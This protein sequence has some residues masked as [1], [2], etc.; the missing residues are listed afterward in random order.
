MITVLTLIICLLLVI[1][2]FLQVRCQVYKYKTEE[3]KQSLESKSRAVNH[4]QTVIKQM[5]NT[6]ANNVEQINNLTN[7]IKFKRNDN[8]N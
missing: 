7:K 8:N 3:L 4:L 2:G 1:T 6:K 5:L